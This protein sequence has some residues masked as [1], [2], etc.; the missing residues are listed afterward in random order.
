MLQQ[1]IKNSVLAIV[2]NCVRLCWVGLHFVCFQS[3]DI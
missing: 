1:N 2:K 3:A